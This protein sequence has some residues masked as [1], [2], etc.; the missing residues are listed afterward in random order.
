M[1][2]AMNLAEHVAAHAHLLDDTGEHALRVQ[3]SNDFAAASGL[4]KIPIHLFIGDVVSLAADQTSFKGQ[5]SRGTCY[6]F[7]ACAAIEAAYKRKYGVELD[8]SEQFAFHINKA[9]ELHGDYMDAGTPPHENNSSYWPF[10]GCSDIVDKL[11]R[12]HIPAETAAPYL[13]GPAMNAI[14]ASTASGALQFGVSTQEE[15]D[16][17]EFDERHIPTPSRQVARYRVADFGALPGDPTPEQVEDVIRGGHE[18]VADVPDHCILIVG[19]DRPRRKFLVKNSWGEGHFIE[20]DY[21]SPT[22][23]IKGG[24]YVID[25]D[26][27]DSAPNHDAFWVGRW[28]HDHDG[29][30]GQ[31]VIRRTTDYRQNQGDPTKLGDYYRDGK[32]YAVNGLTMQDGQALHYWIADTTDKVQ[33]GTPSGQEFWAYVFSNDC[34]K[35]AGD[36][37]WN[38][39]KFGVTLS[40]DDIGGAPSA[41]FGR[42]DWIGDWAM[43]HD[44]WTGTLSITSVD[45]FQAKYHADWDGRTIAVT[46]GIVGGGDFF[47]QLGLEFTA[48][49]PQDFRLWGHTRE[50]DRFSGITLWGGRAFGVQAHR[51]LMAKYAHPIDAKIKLELPHHAPLGDH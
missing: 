9:G 16:A 48:G 47:A 18:V 30:R 6:A 13:G 2:I 24:R 40:R 1:A 44:G 41:G 8:V 33:P 32:R 39:T 4:I 42:G 11:A 29:W 38:G 3:R 31:L 10:M 5:G 15:L 17:F 45:P 46:G 14:K 28:N 20:L 7:A 21:D 26:P 35:A 51:T 43:N 12:S 49:Q 19:F 27:P 34:R 23:P 25:V 50:N 37:T 36:T 22:W